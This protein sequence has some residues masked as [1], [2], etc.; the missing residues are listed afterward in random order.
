MAIIISADEIK[1]K[2]KG[3][4]PKLAEKFHDRSARIADREFEKAV[5][6]V[7]CK[8]VI[9]VCGGTASGKSEFLATELINEKS[10]L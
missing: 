5:E 7:P 6:T 1:K 4:A 3:Y 2:L 8:E 10:I 9:L